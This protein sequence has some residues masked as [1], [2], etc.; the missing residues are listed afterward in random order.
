MSFNYAHRA[1]LGLLAFLSP[2][3]LL[4]VV[5]VFLVQKET[6]VE[7]RYRS[8][9]GEQIRF[10]NLDLQVSKGQITAVTPALRGESTSSAPGYGIFPAAF[11]QYLTVDEAGQVDWNHPN[12]LPVAP[13]S[14]AP[15][16]TLSGLASAGVTLEFGSLWNAARPEDAPPAEGLLC[17][18][19]L[20]EPALITVE[21][22]TIRGGVVLTDGRSANDME[23]SFQSLD[24]TP[25]RILEISVNEGQVTVTFE[26]GELMTT[27]DLN[28]TWSPSGN[29][30]GE[31]VVPLTEAPKMFFRVYKP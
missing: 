10:F 11:R 26:G 2:L 30:D 6:E 18:L 25:P 3:P 27:D 15:A 17:T 4:A 28:G 12:Y 31:H 19:A 9:E 23:V 21:A 14:D 8:T 7:V 24:L 29:K 5:E 16:D 22:N 13:A 20:S 1:F